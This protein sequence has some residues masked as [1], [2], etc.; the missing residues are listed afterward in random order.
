MKGIN[1]WSDSAVINVL[2]RTGRWGETCALKSQKKAPKS[3]CCT[4]WS[5]PAGEHRAHTPF[6]AI[7]LPSWYGRSEKVNCSYVKGS[8]MRKTKLETVPWLSGL[9]Q[10][11]LKRPPPNPQTRKV[12][13]ERVFSWLESTFKHSTFLPRS[14]NTQWKGGSQERWSK[15]YS[16]GA[17]KL[18]V[19]V[20]QGDSS[21]ELS[22]LH[23][24]EIPKERSQKS[25]CS[26]YLGD[27]LPLVTACY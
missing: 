2:I 4:W 25:K 7:Y 17:L 15:G 1:P 8:R 19:R 6:K 23:V 9:C 13:R 16:H 20:P 10:L 24:L 22:G 5:K 27:V 14:S 11:T 3:T 26:P 18:P 12:M 21:S